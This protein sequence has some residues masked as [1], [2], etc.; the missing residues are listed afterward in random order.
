MQQNEKPQESAD[1]LFSHRISGWLVNV[2]YLV[3]TLTAL[4]L[5]AVAVLVLV[6]AFSEF[7]AL[8]KYSISHIVNNL[9]FVLIIM[10]LFRQVFG[11]LSRHQFSLNPF[12]FIGIIASVRGILITQMKV[13]E[14]EVALWDGLAQ[15]AIYG[16]V[17]FIMVLCYYLSLKA[18]KDR[19]PASE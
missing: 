16:V 13:A 10:E 1:S 15:I 17:V 8:Q 14:R 12:L 2:D 19:P 11:Q 7:L 4:G 18:E 9:M 5:I 6:E 3:L